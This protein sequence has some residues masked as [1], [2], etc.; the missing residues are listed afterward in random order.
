MSKLEKTQ[1]TIKRSHSEFL[2]GINDNGINYAF[3]VHVSINSS[4]NSFLFFK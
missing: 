2:L 4:K 1:R 3:T